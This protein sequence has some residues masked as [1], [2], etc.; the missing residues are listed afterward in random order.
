MKKVLFSV[1]ILASFNSFACKQE[2]QFIAPQVETT[3]NGTS[4]LVKVIEFSHFTPSIICPL[5]EEEVLSEGFLIQTQE[6]NCQKI[7]QISGYLVRDQV[8]DVILFD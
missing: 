1:L 8:S 7:T 3:F 2:A 6:E 5:D 4:C